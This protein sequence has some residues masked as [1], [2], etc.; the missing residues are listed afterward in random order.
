MTRNVTIR[1]VPDDTADALAARARR[2]GQSLQEYLLGQLVEL[3]ARPDI[4]ELMA[5]VRS[6]KLASDLHLP[7]DRI[8][9]LRD[10]GRRD[11]GA[12]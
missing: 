3:A 6:R 1:H 9:A 4:D 12:S 11:R 5:S 7:P 10:E 8:L 2:R